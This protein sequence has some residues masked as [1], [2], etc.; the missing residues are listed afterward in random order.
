MEKLSTFVNTI[1]ESN[2]IQQDLGAGDK[3]VKC[4]AV[5]GL[6]AS[7][8]ALWKPISSYVRGTNNE[9]KKVPVKISQEEK[10]EVKEPTSHG[11]SH[12][13]NKY[14]G[15]WALLTD[16][17]DP[18]TRQ[19]AI[20][21]AKE[22]FN[23]IFVVKKDGPQNRIATSTSKYGVKV[24]FI[25]AEDYMHM[26]SFCEDVLKDKDISVVVTGM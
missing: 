11:T 2:L 6:V 18:M 25:T 26:G 16:G 1:K 3:V 19:I 8:K 23:L 7:I 9:E 12:L 24:E 5:I 17:T 14:G 20:E 10:K 21:L 4:L 13:R 22:G 15:E